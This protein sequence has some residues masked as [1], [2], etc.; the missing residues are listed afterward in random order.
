MSPSPLEKRHDELRQACL[1]LAARMRIL[2][3]HEEREVAFSKC[4][5]CKELR[6]SNAKYLRGESE[7]LCRKAEELSP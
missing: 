6:E 5:K 1:A 3:D 7:A 2:A 4:Q